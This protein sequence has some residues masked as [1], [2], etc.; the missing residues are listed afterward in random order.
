[1]VT[2]AGKAWALWLSSVLSVSPPKA[3]WA[4]FYEFKHPFLKLSL[5]PSLSL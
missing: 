4:I 3:P 5:S 2:M 1:V